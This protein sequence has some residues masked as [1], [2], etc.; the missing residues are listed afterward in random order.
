VED[1]LY[2][3]PNCTYGDERAV[4]LLKTSPVFVRIGCDGRINVSQEGV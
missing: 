4:V 2:T 3:F 1:A